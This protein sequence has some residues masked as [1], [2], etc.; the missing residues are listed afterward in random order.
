MLKM[1]LSYD[2]A[3]KIGRH[4]SICSPYIFEDTRFENEGGEFEVD[5]ELIFKEDDR[6][7]CKECGNYIEE[8]ECDV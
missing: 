7:M 8:C 2:E 6:G 4:I 5:L 3:Q 1:I